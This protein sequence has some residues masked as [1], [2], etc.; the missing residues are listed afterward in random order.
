M[1]TGDKKLSID[2]VT[3]GITGQMRLLTIS[4]QSAT[5]LAVL[6]EEVL[7]PIKN[8]QLDR[9]YASDTDLAS[10]SLAER[11]AKFQPGL[12][13]PCIPA[14]TM[15]RA[16]AMLEAVRRIER[17]LPMILVLENA[18]PCEL[19]QLMSLGAADFSLMP[20]RPEDLIPRLLRWH[21]PGL[22]REDVVLQ[23]NEKL[24]LRQFIGGSRSFVQAVKSI[25]K[26]AR[27]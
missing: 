12:L 6:L 14:Q 21:R 5:G 15:D 20:L 11:V 18:A 3:P 24:G 25:S 27:C 19:Q 8:I 22:S 23:L 17:D 10:N 2:G 16:V 1:S 4:P 7:S 13:L 26:F 9:V